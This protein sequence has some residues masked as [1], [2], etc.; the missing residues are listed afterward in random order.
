M[1]HQANEDHL[2]LQVKDPK[3]QAYFFRMEKTLRV[4]HSAAVRAE[5][6]NLTRDI[7]AKPTDVASSIRTVAET[8]ARAGR[9]KVEYSRS[10]ALV[11][12]EIF[13][14]LR[15][16]SFD[17]SVMFR[18][19]LVDAV[20]KVFD[21]YYLKVNLWHLGGLD[22]LSSVEEEMINVAAFAGDLFAQGLLPT[23]TV[24]DS[25][26]ANLVYANQVS[27][28]HCRALHIFL[29]HA[30]AHIG[31]SI[32]LGTLGDVRKQLI[33]CIRGPPIAYDRMAQLWV[34]ECCAVIDQTVE[35]D[36]LA[37]LGKP[38]AVSHQFDRVLSKDGW[39]SSL[40]A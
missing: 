10:C 29:L 3:L 18:S 32:G 17:A 33:R 30:K 24:N 15:S 12:Q 14:E 31:P 35:Q 37:C 2:P 27:T 9:R 1:E 7:V 22:G 39:F 6:M 26:L 25:I 23:Q 11:A 5:A 8:L 4:C 40:I 28:I 20:M 21:G 36:R 34:I 13:C 19:C 38:V 16:I